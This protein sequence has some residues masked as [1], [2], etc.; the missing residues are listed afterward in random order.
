MSLSQGGVKG[1]GNRLDLASYVCARVCVWGGGTRVCL[2]GSGNEGNG[3]R[4]SREPT[5][6]W[7]EHCTVSQESLILDSSI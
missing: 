5:R 1:Q 7:K 3:K 2:G 4:K 6:V